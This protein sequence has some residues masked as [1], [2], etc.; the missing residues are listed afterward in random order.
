MC[1]VWFRIFIMREIKRSDLA[2]ES[3]INLVRRVQGHFCVGQ[4]D[5]DVS[6]VLQFSTGAGKSALR[7]RQQ[8]RTSIL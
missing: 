5:L 4:S 1:L 3:G 7:L 2:L 6:N 8:L